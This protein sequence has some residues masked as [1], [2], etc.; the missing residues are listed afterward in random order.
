MKSAQLNSA[1]FTYFGAVFWYV[2]LINA[3]VLSLI[4]FVSG[5]SH[6]QGSD[7]DLER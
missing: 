5:V 7:W 4:V 3:S 2:K 1:S 6:G